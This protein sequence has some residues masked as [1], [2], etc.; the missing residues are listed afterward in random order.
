M[1]LARCSERCERRVFCGEGAKEAAVE[2]FPV[3]VEQLIPTALF[4]YQLLHEVSE[5]E[6]GVRIVYA[7]AALSKRPQL[8]RARKLVECLSGAQARAEF[9]RRGFVVAVSNPESP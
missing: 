7:V 9:E 3:Y 1:I 4:L 5:A 6:S 2:G 8:P